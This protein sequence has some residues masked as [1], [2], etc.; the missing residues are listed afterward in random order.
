MNKIKICFISTTYKPVKLFMLNNLKSINNDYEIFIVCKDAKSLNKYLNGYDFKLINLSFSRKINLFNDLIC[1][2]KLILILN[3]HRFSI[4]HSM[5]PKTGLLSMFASYIL[6]IKIRIHTFTGQV[7]Y[8]NKTSSFFLFILKISDKIISKLSTHLLCDSFSQ[9]NF[10]INNNIVVKEKIKVLGNG[11]INGIDISNFKIESFSKKKFKLMLNIDQNDFV[12]LYVGR[13]NNDKGI[14]NLLELFSSIL[15]SNRNITLL[16]VGDDE[17]QL[18]K[19]IKKKYFKLSNK[20]IIID[21]DEKIEK[22]YLIADLFISLSHREGFG[23]VLMEAGS[24][25][26]P[27]IASDIYG[28]NEIIENGYNGYLVNNKNI[29]EIEKKFELLF[30]NSNLRIKLGINAKNN[31]EKKYSQK[32]IIQKF[33]EYYRSL[34]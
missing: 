32:I 28:Y 22:Y 2:L 16:L 21:F 20:I 30:N 12:L 17:M 34:V 25:N 1:L 8:N 4:V 3:K 5:N 33:N 9:K 23:N 29:K 10:L 31:I 13:F 19:I 6:N 27:C 15:K 18:K 24:A 26:L 7:W 14:I 11:S